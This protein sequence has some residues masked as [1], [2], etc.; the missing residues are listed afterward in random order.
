MNDG[1]CVRIGGVTVR[2]IAASHEFLDPDTFVDYLTV[3][4]GGRIRAVRPSLL[5][6]IRIGRRQQK[7]EG[8]LG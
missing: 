2:A 5:T 3:K 4:Y 7:G 8:N 1:G 6:P